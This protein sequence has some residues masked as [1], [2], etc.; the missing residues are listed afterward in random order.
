MFTSQP[1][2]DSFELALDA[3]IDRKAHDIVVLDVER[4]CSFSD[5]FIICTG[6]SIRQTQA[7]ADSVDGTLR[8]AGFRSAHMEGYSE[9]EWILLDY[10][11][12]VVHIFTARA[13]EFYNLERLWRAGKRHEIAKP[14]EREA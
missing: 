5:Q 2:K 7:I 12:F 13:R 4:L 10:L 9:G 6:T 14:A 11:D 8:A 3:A 1:E